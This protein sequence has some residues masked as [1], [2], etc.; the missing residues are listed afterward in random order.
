MYE[1]EK[2]GDE[3][4]WRRSIILQAS[5]ERRKKKSKLFEDKRTPKQKSNLRVK[6]EELRILN[7][8]DFHQNFKDY[9][10]LKWYS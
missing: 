6:K 4:Y 1:R 7:L 2:K 9:S 3:G 10:T 8:C 5:M